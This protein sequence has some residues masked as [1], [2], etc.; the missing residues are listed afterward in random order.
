MSCRAP[1]TVCQIVQPKSDEPTTE[2][3]TPSQSQY[4]TRRIANCA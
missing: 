4:V 3:L 2:L 1:Q